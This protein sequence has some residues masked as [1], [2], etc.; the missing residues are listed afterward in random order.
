DPSGALVGRLLILRQTQSWYGNEDVKLTD[1][2]LTEL[3]KILLWAMAGWRTL[4]ER[5]KFLQPPSAERIITD[6]E[7]LSSP[8]ST[9]I[10]EECEV[11]PGCEV[12]IGD[13]YARWKEW[14]E[15]KGR[16]HPGSESVFGRD[17][18]AAL[19]GLDTRQ[20]R[21]GGERVRVYVGI[22]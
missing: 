14:C 13:L 7:D 6:L 3:P 20:P 1:R 22:R 8:V 4:N 11:G 21:V 19:P 9:F 5:G 10:R 18:R 16:E 12:L 17:L 15:A 2:L